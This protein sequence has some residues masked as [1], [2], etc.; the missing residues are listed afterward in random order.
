[1]NTHTSIPRLL[2]LNQIIGD[3]SNGIEPLIPVKRAT[4]WKGVKE[5]RF[6]PAFKLS[7]QITVWKEEDIN[8]FIDSVSKSNP[9]K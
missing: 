5:G 9:A 7:P 6:P 4:W 1:M 8:N 3:A 2:R